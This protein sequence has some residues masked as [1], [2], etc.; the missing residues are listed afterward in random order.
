MAENP[1]YY[2][3]FAVHCVKVYSPELEC[4]KGRY[5]NFSWQQTTCHKILGLIDVQSMV[6][7]GNFLIP[8]IPLE[9]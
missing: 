1:V 5:Q 9:Q 6:Y 7:S 2:V 8:P 3:A 4:Q